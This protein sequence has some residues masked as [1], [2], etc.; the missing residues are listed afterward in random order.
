MSNSTA[1]AS[2]DVMCVSGLVSQHN[3]TEKEAVADCADGIRSRLAS[4]KLSRRVRHATQRYRHQQ[5]SQHNQRSENGG[6]GGGGAS[7]DAAG[8]PNGSNTNRANGPGEAAVHR[9]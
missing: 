2:A 4:L 8:G 7:G 3:V 6:G 5:R 9:L 1:R